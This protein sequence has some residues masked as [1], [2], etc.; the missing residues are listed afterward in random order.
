MLN[1]QYLQQLPQQKINIIEIIL[2]HDPQF[3]GAAG[4]DQRD[5]G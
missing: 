1:N 2:I 3:L 4:F 5:L